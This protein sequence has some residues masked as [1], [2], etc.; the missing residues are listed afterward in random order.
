MRA[1]LEFAGVVFDV[2]RGATVDDAPRG[3]GDEGSLRIRDDRDVGR[4][5]REEGREDDG[6]KG[7]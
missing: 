6:E 3:V 1:V 4:T 7:G 5:S 2:K